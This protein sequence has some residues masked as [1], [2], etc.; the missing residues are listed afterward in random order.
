[1]LMILPGT[2]MVLTICCPSRYFAASEDEMAA[3]SSSQGFPPVNTIQPCPNYPPIITDKPNC[4]QEKDNDDQEY[5]SNE[6]LSTPMIS[7]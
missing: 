5:P 1:M 6:D 7:S 2:T 4:N 3:P